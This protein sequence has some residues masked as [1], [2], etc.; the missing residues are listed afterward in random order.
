MSLR[1]LVLHLGLL[2]SILDYQ[3]M[4][5]SSTGQPVTQIILDMVGKK[6]VIALIV[7]DVS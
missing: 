3:T 5:T 1:S 7:S 6:G 2:F 4:V